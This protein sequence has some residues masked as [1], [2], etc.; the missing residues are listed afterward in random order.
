MA[1]CDVIVSG[2]LFKHFHVDLGFHVAV[3]NLFLSLDLFFLGDLHIKIGF[4]LLFTS[5]FNF[6][7][8]LVFLLLLK[9]VLQR[10]H[11]PHIVLFGLS[12][13][14]VSTHGVRLDVLGSCELIRQLTV[15]SR[16]SG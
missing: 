7:E 13:R 9:G 8:S 15:I 11:V 2:V 12:H 3:D 1:V 4:H 16:K 14:R 5:P 6:L 10:Q